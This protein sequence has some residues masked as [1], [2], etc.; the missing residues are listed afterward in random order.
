[1][2]SISLHPLS[3]AGRVCIAVPVTER[4][5]PDILRMGAE[6]ACR[7]EID[8]IEWRADAFEHW[9]DTDA[10]CRVLLSLRA[11]CK[12]PL[13]FTIRTAAEGG[14][15][16]P[17]ATQY[18]ALLLAAAKTGCAQFIDVEMFSCPDEQALTNALHDLGC[19]VIGSNHDFAKT[20]PQEELLRRLLAMQAMGADVPKLAVMPNTESDVSALMAA[21][22]CMRAQSDKPFIAL[23]MG[24]LGQKTRVLCREM[25]TCMSF[26]C[27]GA[28]SAPGQMEAQSL[29]RALDGAG[30]FN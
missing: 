15:C 25:G 13:I 28:G 6:L 20:P 27:V 3:T 30:G 1:M 23:S 22:R 7:D 2:P 14:L 12:K 24:A 19:A 4:T 10:I 16:A 18:R 21:A 29:R 8:L 9:Q 17:D 26:G 11:A 5:E